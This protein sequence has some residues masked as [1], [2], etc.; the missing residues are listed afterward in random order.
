MILCR[1]ETIKSF[2]LIF[3]RKFLALI[4][5]LFKFQVIFKNYYTY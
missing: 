2:R 1:N 4:E 3:V 5:S